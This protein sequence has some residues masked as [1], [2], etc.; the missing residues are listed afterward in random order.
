M[1]VVVLLSGGALLASALT[2]ALT[3]KPTPFDSV[4][5]AH[6]PGGEAFDRMLTAL[7]S[8][9]IGV[10]V[11]RVSGQGQD[12][13]R[14]AS[15]FPQAEV[16]IVA[17]QAWPATS[18]PAQRLVATSLDRPLSL[19]SPRRSGV[20]FHQPRRQNR[21]FDRDQR[22]LVRSQQDDATRCVGFGKFTCTESAADGEMGTSWQTSVA[23]PIDEQN[24]GGTGAAPGLSASPNA[25]SPE[26]SAKL[27][28]ERNGR[29]L[30]PSDDDP[31]TESG[32]V[33]AAARPAADVVR[34]TAVVPHA[35][36]ASTPKEATAVRAVAPTRSEAPATR[37]EVAAT[38]AD[39]AATRS[40]VA[41]TRADVS[42]TRSDVAATRSDVA[43]TRSDVGATRADVA[44]TRS[45]VAATRSDVSATRSDVA[46]TRSDVAA[47][48]SDV[49]ATRS[50]VAA[51][52][53][54]VAATRS[55]V[56]AT[57]SDLSATRSD[58]AATRSGV[59]A[60]REDV[61]AAA[62]QAKMAREVVKSA[63]PGRGG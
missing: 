29:D 41:A 60:A 15:P 61:Q 42:A 46:A 54:D 58:V 52:R 2:F 20:L 23:F 24:T 27:R 38:R 18:V 63:L 16:Q 36:T 35:V 53:T 12:A 3:L 31:P 8:S 57:R 33:R 4:V 26:S 40:D 6:L 59:S 1:R 7:R 14:T 44:A 56:A 50:D 19:F 9:Q 37:S 49:A 43:A 51:T 48:R 25:S 22:D 39:V 45:D 32:V 47:I 5:T 11:S 10:Q 17:P 28:S 34:D 13:T 62:E 55:D 21:S 30:G